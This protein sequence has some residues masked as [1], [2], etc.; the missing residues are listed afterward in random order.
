MYTYICMYTHIHIYTYIYIY[1]HT[2]T[3]MY[4]YINIYIY[5]YIYIY[6]Y[7]YYIHTYIYIYIYIY[8]VKGSTKDSNNSSKKCLLYP[9]LYNNQKKVWS[10]FCLVLL[11]SKLQEDIFLM[12]MMFTW[13]NYKRGVLKNLSFTCET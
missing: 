9:T 2:Y 5:I 11:F 7:I 4:I 12:M 10:S 6:T 3:Y 13:K 1:I 8:P